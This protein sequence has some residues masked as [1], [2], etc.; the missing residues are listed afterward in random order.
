MKSTRGLGGSLLVEIIFL[1]LGVG[2]LFDDRYVLGGITVVFALGFLFG[3]L[4]R[5]R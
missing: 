5:L 4:R 3:E 2:L 1:L